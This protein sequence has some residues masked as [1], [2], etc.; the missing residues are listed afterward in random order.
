MSLWHIR[1]SWCEQ[2]DNL[3]PLVPHSVRLTQSARMLLLFSSRPVFAGRA[4]QVT[5]LTGLDWRGDRWSSAQLSS[6]GRT[7]QT[8]PVRLRILAGDQRATAAT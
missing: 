8:G 4:L 1:E 3:G 5:G 6:G 7:G 2:D